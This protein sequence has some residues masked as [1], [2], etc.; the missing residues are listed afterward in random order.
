MIKALRPQVGFATNNVKET[1]L[2]KL[3]A[4][5][6][7]NEYITSLCKQKL[8]NEA[9][10]AFEFLQKKTGFCLTLSTYAYLISACS[11]L[12]SLEHGKKIHDHML[13]SKSHPDLTLQNH[14]LNMY[15][16]C[17]S[18]KDAQKVF[19]AMPE[20]NVV[21]WTSVIAGYSQN[22][23]SQLGY[24]LEALC[25]FK[26]MLHQ[27]VYLPNEFIFG[28][29]FSACSS[30]LQPEYGRQLHGM[31][32]KFG[33][34]RDVFAGCSLCDMYAKCG[35]L[36]CARVV[37]YQIGRPD[38]VAWN[39]IIAGFA[40]GG[41]AKEAIAFFSQMRHQGL[42]PDEITVRS[43]LCA[44]TSPSEL[45]QGMQVHG[46][47]NK[48][49]LDLDVPVCNTLLTMYAKCSELRDAIFFFEEMRCNA[50][51]V[52]WNA[53]LTACMRHDQAEEVFRL[54]KLMCISQ[55]RP[56]YITLTNVL[57]AS[58]ETVS[59]EIG[60]QVHC[61]ALKTGLNCDTSV[62]NGL[63]DLY[64]KCG[65][66]KTAH[67]IFDSMINPDVVSWSS[68]ILGHVGLVEEGWKLYGT[69]EKEFGIAPTREH[70]SCMV[71]LLARAGCLNEAE[72]F[73]HQMAFDPDIVVWKTLLAACKTHGNVDVGKRAA[74]NILKIDPSNSAAH[75]LLC[76]IYASKGNWEDVARLRSL[77]KQRGVRKVPGQ[78]WIEVKDRIHVFF[79]ED[80]LHP[81]R[82]KIYTMLEELLLQMLDAGYV[83]F[84]K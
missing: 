52:S 57:G 38:L 42:I 26:E 16:K 73:I 49:G 43:L 22:G 7:S 2:S 31:S 11:Y 32:I 27:G 81:E 17:K 24:E 44:C 51:L 60:N 37:F 50:D 84:Q 59:I 21:S 79:V 63:I 14:I 47:I 41:D 10:K 12:R 18:L 71:D 58:A 68:L 5:Q 19:D 76:N 23:F 1:V 48:M 20:R 75:V 69:M 40:Y 25:Y 62:T 80:S 46:Y 6:S 72:G 3:R 77:M 61:Y 35:L 33:L 8:F 78:S 4:E 13:K 28:S 34:G 45:Y 83:P 53:I 15:G 9:I 82:N 55:H 56:D 67:K 30:L 54:L 29:V 74:E 65:S 64:A 39:A 36:S 70:C 66:L